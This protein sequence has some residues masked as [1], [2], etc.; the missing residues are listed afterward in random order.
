[1]TFTL[2]LPITVPR[3]A[4]FTISIDPVSLIAVHKFALD[5]SDWSSSTCISFKDHVIAV[6]SKDALGRGKHSFSIVGA[7]EGSL[8]AAEYMR[9]D[10]KHIVNTLNPMEGTSKDSLV[11]CVATI[12]NPLKDAQAQTRP[13]SS[14]AASARSVP[15]TQSPPDS[16]AR[17]LL[18]A[19]C[20]VM[21]TPAVSVVSTCE[22]AISQPSHSS[23]SAAPSSV[24]SNE[25]GS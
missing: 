14:N 9:A 8:P 13:S 20:E 17:P 19:Q 15:L 10:L 6:T 7:F 12:R 1:V 23:A 11:K 25:Q 3:G 5:A 24:L 4:S 2:F 16:S 22:F 21:Q 18:P